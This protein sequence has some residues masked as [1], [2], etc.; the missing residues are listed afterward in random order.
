MTDKESPLADIYTLLGVSQMSPME[1]VRTR[2]YK[3]TRL[4]HRELAVEKDIDKRNKLLYDLKFI[5]IAYDILSDPVTRTDYDLRT[6]GLRG[7]PMPQTPEEKKPGELG[8]RLHLKIGELLNVAGLLEAS[9]LEIACDM[10]KAMPEMQFGSFLVK[11]GFIEEYQLE[12]V[13]FAQKLLRKGLI[14]VVQYQAAMEELE[15]SGVAVS[16]TVVERGYVTQSDLDHLEEVEAEAQAELNRPVEAPVYTQ[17]SLKPKVDEQVTSHSNL[18]AQMLPPGSPD[19]VSARSS[20][21]GEKSGML[22]KL[23][24]GAQDGDATAPPSTMGGLLSAAKSGFD[25]VPPGT[26]SGGAPLAPAAAAPPSAPPPIPPVEA[27]DTRDTKDSKEAKAQ[28]EPKESRKKRNVDLQDVSAI[29]DPALNRPAEDIAS[30]T[31]EGAAYKDELLKL[32]DIP[33]ARQRPI[34]P[35]AAQVGYVDNGPE[36]LTADDDNGQYGDIFARSETGAEASDDSELMESSGVE[37][38][39]FVD[40]QDESDDDDDDDEEE[41]EDAGSITLI[42]SERT[43]MVDAGASAGDPGASGRDKTD[44]THERIPAF[45]ASERTLLDADIPTSMQTGDGGQEFADGDAR[46]QGTTKKEQATTR[47]KMPAF[48]PPLH[49]TFQL[50]EESAQQEEQKGEDEDAGDR[51]LVISNA[52]PSNY[53]LDWS[54]PEDEEGEEKPTTASQESEPIVDISRHIDLEAIEPQQKD[55]SDDELKSFLGEEYREDLNELGESGRPLWDVEDDEFI[56]PSSQKRHDRSLQQQSQ[57]QDEEAQARRVSGG[58]QRLK[59]PFELQLDSQG[60]PSG[61][62]TGEEAV[63]E[64]PDEE[65]L[66][67]SR[68]A[69]ADID[70]RSISGGYVHPAQETAEKVATT[71]TDSADSFVEA[72]DSLET[73]EASHQQQEARRSRPHIVIGLEDA[74]DNEETS[75]EERSSDGDTTVDEAPIEDPLADELSE[76]PSSDEADSDQSSADESVEG[77]QTSPKEISDD[78]VNAEQMLDE[79]SLDEPSDEEGQDEL[80]DAVYEPKDADAQPEEAPD[81]SERSEQETVDVDAVEAQIDENS[82]LVKTTGDDEKAQTDESAD[83]QTESDAQQEKEDE[84]AQDQEDDNEAKKDSPSG[85]DEKAQDEPEAQDEKSA[86]SKD[87]KAKDEEDEDDTAGDDKAASSAAEETP[88][89]RRR[90]MLGRRHHRGKP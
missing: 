46:A 59:N 19:V 75:K 88:L 74:D 87:T 31:Y 72:A 22:Q 13:L 70:R 53:Q 36:L 30:D 83:R 77:D 85:D 12:A 33:D 67:E 84:A 42:D 71:S 37:F 39:G 29:M 76:E 40:T 65:A 26:V 64:V 32:D 66:D 15:S 51:Q 34:E 18:L 58:W 1:G 23:L 10:H 47:D 55:D 57:A 49:N 41:E 21:N 86:E 68:S 44:S 16:E 50:D 5:C 54:S 79:P 2:F 89:A 63:V 28:K 45:A 38:Q 11:Q 7:V 24:S 6:M 27:R 48:R 56:V 20:G 69:T 14:T 8:Q 78:H 62:S 25:T 52:V 73:E 60:K 81:S 43:H 80:A 35:P 9:E 3:L 4:I 90:R 17:P 82:Q 61:Q